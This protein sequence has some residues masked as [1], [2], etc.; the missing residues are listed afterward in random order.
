MTQ[1]DMSQILAQAQAMQAQLQAAQ[2]EILASEVEGTAGGGLV[3]VTMSGDGVV[4]SVTIDPKVVD[5]EDVDTLQDLVM[6]ALGDAHT[7]ISELAQAKM[8]P[9]SAGM[10]SLGGLF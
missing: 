7:K 3:T 10:D 1:P 8:G 5:P 6:G 9:L 2:A 4:K